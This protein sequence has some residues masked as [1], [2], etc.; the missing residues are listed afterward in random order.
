MRTPRPIDEALSPKRCCELG[1]FPPRDA[2]HS[3]AGMPDETESGP[4]PHVRA[5]MA[6]TDL[7]A[8]P[9]DWIN[10]RVETIELLSHEETRRRVSIDF[11]LFDG[12]LEELDIDEGI[13][14]PISVLTKEPRR[15]F[16][17]RD[18]GGRAIPV[19]GKQQN[20][21]LAHIA[22]LNAAANALADDLTL[23]IFEMLAADLRQVVFAAPA[24]AAD[25]LGFFVGSAEAGDRWRTAVWEDNTCRSLLNA[26]WS[27]Y[28]LFAVLPPDGPNR[29]ILKYSYGDDFN[30]SPESE[31]IRERLAPR[32]LA[33]RVWSPDRKPFVIECPGAPRAAS[34][35]V[36]I[37]IPEELRFDTAVL[38]DFAALEPVSQPDINVNRASLY[39]HGDIDPGGDVNAYVEVAPERTGRTFQAAGTSVIVA[40][41]LWVG[42]ASGLDAK[43]PGAAV[44]I[45]LA[46]AALFS[47]LTAVQG[48]RLVK[49]VFS[50]ARRWLGIVTLAALAGSASLAME[51][52]DRHPV[53]VWR[54][55]A[56][57]CTIAAVRLAWS[58][59]RA[60]A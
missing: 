38:Y 19:L 2:P 41:L 18:E 29:R 49:S 43:N 6:C 36:E 47:G 51:V 27:N 31:R 46:G 8:H 28:V 32:E 42:V 25:A 23:E 37:A 35:H 9:V 39:A 11:T 40:L 15:N 4:P 21:E 14:V 7:I 60:P 12:Q 45:L 48:H 13:A 5:G 3:G 26:L 30:L 33:R 24:A 17:L 54:W 50:A 1:W 57:A 34:F 55:A 22:L 53:S 52:P 44:S 58:A 16:D 20:G 56:I 10:R 59:I